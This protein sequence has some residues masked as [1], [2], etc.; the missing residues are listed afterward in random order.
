MKA[1]LKHN[2]HSAGSSA[3]SSPPS[4]PFTDDSDAARVRK[5]VQF[6]A[7]TCNQVF[8]ADEWDRSPAD[9]TPRLTYHDMLELK[10]I[11]RSLP[12]AEQPI[13]PEPE[14]EPEP[15]FLL[16]ADIDADVDHHH[17][18]PQRQLLRGVPIGLLPLLPRQAPPRTGPPIARLAAQPLR[19]AQVHILVSSAQQSACIYIFIRAY[20]PT[21]DSPAF[22]S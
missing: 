11:Q 20:E 1:C 3:A 22:A 12:R 4:S 16:N 2:H 10:E 18:R 8:F 17:V 15:E 19:T 21:R 9:V 13:D 5:C 7:E 14:A 6:C